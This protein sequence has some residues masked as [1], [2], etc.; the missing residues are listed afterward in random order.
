MPVLFNLSI[1]LNALSFIAIPSVSLA[2]LQRNIIDTKYMN[3]YISAKPMV[4]DDFNKSSSIIMTVPE[5][6]KD[7]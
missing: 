2:K 6:A 1:N 5:L 7:S 3:H 4:K